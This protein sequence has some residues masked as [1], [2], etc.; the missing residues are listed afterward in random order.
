[1]KAL[2]S[3]DLQQNGFIA[4]ATETE[5]ELTCVLLTVTVLKALDKK[6]FNFEGQS[7]RRVESSYDV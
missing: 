5:I 4:L 7:E 3:L 1:M 6:Q 2:V